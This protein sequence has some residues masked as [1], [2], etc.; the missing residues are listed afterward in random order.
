MANAIFVTPTD[1]AIDRSRS[2]MLENINNVRANVNET[3]LRVKNFN[4]R[5]FGSPPPQPQNELKS[6]GEIFSD[7]APTQHQF[8]HSVRCIEADLRELNTYLSN[9]ENSI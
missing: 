3:M 1:S 8:M 9:M 6:P 5:H 7:S 2:S 4:N